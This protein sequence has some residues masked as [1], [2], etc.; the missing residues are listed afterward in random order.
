MWIQLFSHQVTTSYWPVIP[1]ISLLVL[2]SAGSSLFPKFWHESYKMVSVSLGLVVAFWYV[3]YFKQSVVVAETI[4]EYISFISLLIGLYVVAGTIHIQPDIESSPR[5]NILFLVVGAFL[6]NIIGTTGASILLIR[7]FIQLNKQQLKPYH[8]VFF[9]F[10]ISNIGG[11]LT[12]IVDPPLFIGFLKGIPF[13][14]TLTHLFLPWVITLSILIGIFY[15]FEK[16]NNKHTKKLETSVP[17]NK[18]TVTGKRNFIWLAFMVLTVFL[19]PN[20]LSDLPTIEFEGHHFSFARELLQLIIAISCIKTSNKEALKSNDFTYEPIIEVAYLFFG[21]FLTM[22]PALQLLQNLGSSG[23]QLSLMET[24][25]ATGI[26]SAFLDNAPAYLNFL[27]FSMAGFA[28]NINNVSEVLKFVTSDHIG[29]LLAI[30]I[31]SVFWGALTYVGNG[32]NF[33]VKSIAE[34]SGVKMPTFMAYI[35]RFAI[36]ILIPI[37]LLIALY[38]L[39]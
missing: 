8:I 22:M 20:I 36:P 35:F 39:L 6:T 10:I 30:S 38:L 37:L 31:S 26:S 25:F 21:I 13:F 2:I 18:I 7:P 33:M 17:T 19:D 29:Y 3:V 11:L 4:S 23:K 15:L 34:A 16:R 32:P 1:F 14:F 9:I 24:Y 27:T 5:N 28:I 12:P